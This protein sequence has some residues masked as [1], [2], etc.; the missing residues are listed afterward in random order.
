[1]RNPFPDDEQESES[2]ADRLDGIAVYDTDVGTAV[3][4]D[5]EAAEF[6][7]ADSIADEL[8]DRV[9]TRIG[10]DRDPVGDQ[11]I[12][13]DAHAALKELIESEEFKPVMQTLTE[14]ALDDPGSWIEE[15]VPAERFDDEEFDACA[16]VPVELRT[17][18]LKLDRVEVAPPVGVAH[19]WAVATLDAQFERER[20]HRESA[21]DWLATRQTFEELDSDSKAG[22]VDLVGRL[23]DAVQVEDIDIAPAETEV[24]I[25]YGDLESELDETGHEFTRDA[26]LIGATCGILIRRVEQSA[27][28]PMPLDFSA[29]LQGAGPEDQARGLRELFT[30]T[31]EAEGDRLFEFF[32]PGPGVWRCVAFWASEYARLNT[33]SGVLATPMDVRGTAVRVGYALAA[34]GLREA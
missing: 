2:A 8:I 21:R 12:D 16:H 32:T 33:F 4:V 31:Y 7:A 34:L 25:A 26:A 20:L 19:W 30:E 5:F 28:T 29:R 17:G 23:R 14:E 9:V 13:A 15:P 1:M 11:A 27:P 18:R 6:A 3:F 10:Q 22:A 24:L